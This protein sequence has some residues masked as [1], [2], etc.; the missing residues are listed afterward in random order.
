M[1]GACGLQQLPV[2]AVQTGAVPHHQRRQPGRPAMGLDTQQTLTQPVTPRRRGCR[3]PLPILDRSG[4]AYPLAEQPRLVI[5]PLRIKQTPRLFQL[6]GQAPAFATVNR[7]TTLPAQAKR[8]RQLS[9]T[10]D[11]RIDVKPHVGR[12]ALR[13]PSHPPFNPE[14]AT[15]EGIRQTVIQ[16]RLPLHACPHQPQQPQ[17]DR[18]RSKKHQPYCKA[19]QH[20]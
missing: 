19:A 3:Q 17:P 16:C 2:F 9:P 14:G 5:K 13:Q 20:P 10:R 6:H 7:R 8:A 1:Y 18:V 11:G 15:V 12:R 4:C